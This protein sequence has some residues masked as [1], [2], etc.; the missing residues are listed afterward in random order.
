MFGDASG[1]DGTVFRLIGMSFIASG[2]VAWQRRP[3]N[4]VGV[5]MV[6][7]GFGV[8]VHPLLIQIE[9]SPVQTLAQ[10]MTDWW[11]LVFVVLLLVFPQGG[12]LRGRLDWLL[13]VAFA[14]PLVVLQPVWLLFV[15]QEGLVN[16]LLVWPDAG[17]ADAVDTAQRSILLAA[18]LSLFVTLVWRWLQATAPLRRVLLPTLAGGATMLSFAGMLAA[19]LMSGTR[20]HTLL[21]ITLCVN[22]TVPLAFLAGLLRSRLARVAVGGLLVELRDTV[23]PSALRDALA[24]SL[25]DPSLTLLYWLPEYGS[26]ADADGRPAALPADGGGRATKL[27]ERGDERVAALIHDAS[28]LDEPE[29]VE[30]AC[31][32]AAIALEN[33]RLHADLKAR[34]DE[35]RASRARIVETGD[36][37]RRRLE[38]NL[39]DGAQQRLVALALSLG[40]AESRV[41]ADPELVER[42]LAEAKQE[43]TLG[44]GELRELARGIH[45]GVL[46][47]HGLEVALES[48][49]A[50]A[51]VRVDLDVGLPNRPPEPVEVA[52]YFFVS[53]SLANVAKY[54]QASH[55]TVR[56]ARENGHLLVEVADDGIG[57]ADDTRGS[58]IRGL[59]D[60]VE[61]L[62]GRLRVLSPAG[63]GTRISAEIPCP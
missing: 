34:L 11:S 49:A 18:T 53:E 58:G 10:V 19:D 5:L 9:W 35:L 59:A 27:V 33:A 1:A 61:T 52:A 40:M 63:G 51:P 41:R 38:R 50:R 37:E 15:E 39:H 23:S 7:T 22:A 24:A 31:A 17:I 12:R 56:I 46:S 36:I 13:V 48:L 42:L 25:G 2:L 32:V 28:L 60:R 20:S 44:L 45:P 54:A 29:L 4:R 47:D 43:L 8:L 26:W 55:A 62:G 57:G 30:S 21:L 14:I 3:G 16:D 6:V